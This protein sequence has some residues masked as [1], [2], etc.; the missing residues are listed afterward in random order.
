MNKTI[1]EKI[2]KKEWKGGKEEG[3]KTGRME[4]MDVWQY[5]G[6]GNVWQYECM[7]V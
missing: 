6:S 1:I 5:G 7:N 3:W 4:W 2:D